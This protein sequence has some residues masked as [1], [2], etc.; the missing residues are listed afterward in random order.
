MYKTN[1][2]GKANTN[3]FSNPE[4]RHKAGRPKKNKLADMIR[5]QLGEPVT[6]SQIN[7]AT[8]I[9]LNL[10]EQQLLDIKDCK[11]KNKYPLFVIT[12]TEALLKD[13]KNKNTDTAIKLIERIAGRAPQSVEIRAEV[14]SRP[15]VDNLTERQ[16]I[17]LLTLLSKIGASGQDSDN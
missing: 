12:L 16:Q 8:A 3:G 17:E 7:E 5:E 15:V 10:S 4:N 9:L 2:G 6:P 14:I 13:K 11:D 1:F